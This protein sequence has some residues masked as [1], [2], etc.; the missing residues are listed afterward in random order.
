MKS[1]RLLLFDRDGTLTYEN[2]D[3]HRELMALKA[4]PFTGSLLRDLHQAGHQLA[5]V[6]NQSGVARG[7]WSLKDVEA[8]H[9]RFCREWGVDPIFYVCPHHPGDGCP[10]RKPQPGLIRQA[11]A[12]HRSGPEATLMVGDS[13]ADFGA[14]QSAG[15]AFALVLT[16]RGRLTRAQLPQPPEM[17]LDS[18][19]DLRAYVV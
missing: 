6:T 8:V 19:A 9:Q 5:V 3:Y 14:A 10:C 18:I 15:V 1:Y 12:H 17:V 11:M 13:P 2:R 4:Y 7:Y 16:G